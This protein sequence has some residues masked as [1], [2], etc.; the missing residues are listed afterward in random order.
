M[1]VD[2]RVDAVAGQ[3]VD[4]T[5]EMAEAIGLELER[6]SVVLEM[7]VANGN[8]REVHPSLA[9]EG[10]VRLIEEPGEES[11]EETLGPVVADRPPYLPPHQRLVRRISGD[12]VLHVQPTTE[13]DAAKEQ[14]LAVRAEE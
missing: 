14:R 12:E 7:L 9:E 2:N 4:G 13:A 10:S 6:S 5:V 11:L 3:R 1:Q 8:S